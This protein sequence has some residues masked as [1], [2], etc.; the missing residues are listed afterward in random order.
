MGI[1]RTKQSTWSAHLH[2]NFQNASPTFSH[3]IVMLLYLLCLGINGE[4]GLEVG[5]LSVLAF[6]PAESLPTRVEARLPSAS[7]K[8]SSR[9]G[10]WE[11]CF[12]YCSFGVS[13]H[14]TMGI[15]L[16]PQASCEGSWWGLTV[17]L[18][19]FSP[20]FLLS[21]RLPVHVTGWQ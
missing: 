16:R 17:V 1:F 6:P 14:L 7:P 3:A 21:C 2:V 20:S 15:F 13:R 5:Q 12:L 11:A 9:A 8:Q 18:A 4:E 10:G 19:V